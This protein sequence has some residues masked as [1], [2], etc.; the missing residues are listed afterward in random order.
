MVYLGIKI[1]PSKRMR[2]VL[3]E[4]NAVRGFGYRTP[5][6]AETPFIDINVPCNTIIVVPK[7]LIFFGVPAAL[8]PSTVTPDYQLGV[9]IIRRSV[10]KYWGT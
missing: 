8:V 9:D 3:L 7:R 5:P 4:R 1:Y 6:L 2:V 10:L